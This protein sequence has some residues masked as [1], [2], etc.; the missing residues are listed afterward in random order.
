[1]GEFSSVQLRRSVTRLKFDD[2]DDDDCI[3]CLRAVSRYL[4]KSQKYHAT[5][6]IFFSVFK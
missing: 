6:K 2:N 5:V 3:A 1:M 4:E